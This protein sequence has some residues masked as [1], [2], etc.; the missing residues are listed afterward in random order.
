VSVAASTTWSPSAVRGG[1]DQL[2]PV[3]AVSAAISTA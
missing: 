1:L 2:V 3:E